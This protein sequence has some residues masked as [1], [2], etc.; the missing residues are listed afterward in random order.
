MN[1]IS[2]SD[3]DML[4]SKGE[5][6]IN[7]R[8]LLRKSALMLT[9]KNIE[10]AM[11]D[12]RIL[13]EHVLGITREKLL[14]LLDSS[15]DNEQLKI[16]NELLERRMKRE[17]VAK[18]I[19]RREFWGLDFQ[20]NKNTLDPRPDS[21]TLIEFI[22]KHVTSRAKPFRIL[23]LGTGS[24]CL[25][26]S[27]LSELPLARGVGVDICKEA[28][29]LAQGNAKSLSL[30]ERV[31][32]IRSDWYEEIEGKF[33]IILSNPPYIPTGDI[34]MLEDEVS[35]F[36]PYLALDGGKDGLY[37]YR[38]IINNLSCFMEE[39]GIAVFELGAGQYEDVAGIAAQNGLRASGFSRDL[40]GVVRCI[41][42]Q[43]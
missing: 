5:A 23:D 39:D 31:E 43:N 34:A 11:L 22:L 18:I 13:L 29:F 24:G 28:I 12:A 37:C 32:F 41:M 38:E 21:E 36:E 1:S 20:V 9:Q 4:S 33:D 25:I 16:F 6:I 40:G 8:E 19:G 26:L 15:V 3:F 30:N 7:I 27:L 42:V 14:L 35:V 2:I 10:S 17:P